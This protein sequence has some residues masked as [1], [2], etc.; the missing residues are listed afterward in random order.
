MAQIRCRWR[1]CLICV[2]T[3]CLCVLLLFLYVAVMVT[4]AMRKQT[5]ESVHLHYNLG[6]DIDIVVKKRIPDPKD[7]FIAP[8]AIKTG[9]YS[10]TPKSFWDKGDKVALWN[11]LQKAV[12]LQFNPILRPGASHRASDLVGASLLSHSLSGLRG[13]GG[14]SLFTL[15]EQMQDYV[16][17]MSRR[18][19]P[20]LLE[21]R[22]QCGAGDT[23]E[24]APALLL[25]AIKTSALNYRNRRAIRQSWGKAG[26][27]STQMNGG[28]GAYVRRL[29]LLGT[30]SSDLR[31]VSSELLHLESQHYGDLLQWDVWDNS[32]NGTVKQLLFWSWFRDTCGHT[33]FVFEGDDEVFVNTPAL[34]SFLLEQLHGPRAHRP[35]QDFMMGNVEVRGQPSRSSH[36]QEFIP[37]SFY[38]GSYPLYA[39][40]AGRVSSA[41]LLGRLLQV[42]NRVHLFPIEQVY[43]GMCMIR[44][45]VSPDHHPAFFPSKWTKEQEEEPCAGRRVLLLHTHS[46]THMLQLWDSANTELCANATVPSLTTRGT[47]VTNG[48]KKHVW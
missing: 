22:G 8:G 12:D 39:S 33:T 32:L 13:P 24:T 1:N 38:R 30:A 36:S 4:L 31:D 42:S 29:F 19:Y 40:G 37:E 34:V 9:K 27:V 17:S 23:H 10:S 43:V 16:S 11:Q 7:H 20:V 26:W 28:R 46:P 47:K 3:S 35:L 21:P 41:L 14:H 6:E 2:C 45:N 15:P 5:T 44:L 25:L 18:Q 48:I